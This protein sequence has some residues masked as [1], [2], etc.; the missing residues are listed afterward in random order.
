MQHALSKSK[1]RPVPHRPPNSGPF[2]DYVCEATRLCATSLRAERA[3]LARR[4][5]QLA[6]GRLMSAEQRWE[7]EGGNTG[8]YAGQRAPGGCG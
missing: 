3:R 4:E 1:S 2:F 5:H 8:Q 7:G 6:E